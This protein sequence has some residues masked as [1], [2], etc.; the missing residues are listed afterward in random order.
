MDSLFMGCIKI[1]IKCSFLFIVGLFMSCKLNLSVKYTEHDILSELDGAFHKKVSKYYPVGNSD[2]IKY[3]FFLDLEHGYC[4]TAG[5]RIHL[6]ADS[7]NWAIVFE[8][9]GYQ[10]RG[11]YSGIELAYIGNCIK[12]MTE[13]YNGYNY[14]A[15]SKSISLVSHTEYE[16]IR[17]KEGGEGEQFELISDSV[18]FVRVRDKLIN[19]EYDPQLFIKMG[20]VREYNNPR[21]L[22]S[23]GGL[24]RY[25][26]DTQPSVV[27]STESEIKEQFLKDIP[28]IMT[29][30]EFHYF[31]IYNEDNIPSKQELFQLIAKILVTRD[32]TL[33]KPT[34]EPNNHWSNWE[35]GNL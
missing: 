26:N 30:D 10:N 19:I 17:N 9:S 14:I 24:V 1:C 6:Y 35:S 34:K 15:N 25:L 21:N 16:R 2:D 23:Y 12:Y 5:S 20:I 11:D 33:W 3:I 28:K 27:Q 13:H 7:V 18:R 32:S 4:E 8:K 29:L 31:S 22:M